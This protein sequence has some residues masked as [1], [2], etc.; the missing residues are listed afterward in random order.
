[1]YCINRI[2]SFVISI[3]MYDLK[4]LFMGYFFIILQ[5]LTDKRANGPPKRPAFPGL[6]GTTRKAKSITR[7]MRKSQCVTDI[8]E[9]A[10]GSV[11]KTC[12]AHSRER[13]LTIRGLI[14][15]FIGG[16]GMVV[17]GSG[18][19]NH[20]TGTG[21]QD[22]QTAPVRILQVTHVTGSQHWT[23]DT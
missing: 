22:R 17:A 4:K 20:H 10:H 1:M 5:I 21:S 9:T 18:M 19:H 11:Q 16:P 7:N 12:P 14:S 23:T 6:Y 8:H 15:V 2:H 13:D 3:C